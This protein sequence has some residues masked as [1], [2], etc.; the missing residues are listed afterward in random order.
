ME[1]NL[2]S[3]L[4]SHFINEGKIE[5]LWTVQKG[6]NFGAVCEVSSQMGTF[7]M[8]IKMFKSRDTALQYLRKNL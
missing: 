8:P 6:S 3:Q 7:Y 5:T 1:S 4:E 2:Q